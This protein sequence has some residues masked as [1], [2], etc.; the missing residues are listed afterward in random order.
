MINIVNKYILIAKDPEQ[1]FWDIRKNFKKGRVR[2]SKEY[3]PI[4]P[5]YCG[6]S[7]FSCR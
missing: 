4:T 2:V 1:I 3:Q 6:G 7:P 5:G